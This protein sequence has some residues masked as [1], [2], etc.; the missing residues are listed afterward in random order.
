MRF[1]VAC[2]AAYNGFVPYHNFRHVVDVLQATFHFLVE[3]GALPPY[4]YRPHSESKLVTRSPVAAL[5]RPI[6]A[7]TLLV[8]AIG[9]DVGHPGVNNGFLATLNTPLA[10]LY[11]DRS[12]LESFHCAAYSQILRRHW[13]VVYEDRKMRQLMIS[14]ILS[15]DMGLHFD[16]MKKLGDLQ[17][18]I[19]LH[20][21]TNGWDSRQLDEG[22]VLACSLLIKCADISNVARH[23]DTALRWMYILSDEFSRQASMEEELQIK[24]SLLAP[25]KSDLVSLATAQLGFMNLFAMPLFH[26]VTDILPAMSYT[27]EE[28]KTNKILFERKVQ[29]EAALPL[30]AAT[31]KPGAAVKLAEDD[32]R[33]QRA[34]TGEVPRGGPRPASKEGAPTR[35]QKL[36]PP[37]SSPTRWPRAAPKEER[38]GGLGKARGQGPDG[39]MA[40]TSS[41]SAAAAVASPSSSSL[42]SFDVVR[43]LADSDPFHCRDRAPG[44]A[45]AD[46]TAS[47]A[48]GP[49]RCSETTDGSTSGVF[50][51]DWQSQATST[52]TGKAALSPSTKGTSIVSSDSIE[53]GG[54]G[55]PGPELGSATMGKHG[56]PDTVRRHDEAAEGE[57]GPR[58]SGGTI[59]KAEAKGLKKK[60][61][62]FRMKD[63]PFFRRNKGTSPPLPAEADATTNS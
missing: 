18:K 32:E 11:N 3:I 19:R 56:S 10:Q 63:F 43:E 41:T 14:S 55:G 24:S 20:A 16:Y 52:A 36:Q 7:L 15:T 26:G 23:H 59:G 35:N 48:A 25:P 47:T 4:P 6:D 49:Q 27:V 60:P 58:S 5:L 31:S 30:P 37:P 42:S 44:A 13:P 40:A 54:G 50:A 45:A 33:R 17:E 34:V 62:R 39:A 51:G 57:E 53:H 21:G 46:E 28:L 8:T 2:R 12:V 22:R 29:D 61:S 1:L 9:H 38:L